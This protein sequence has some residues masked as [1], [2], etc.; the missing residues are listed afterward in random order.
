MRL[1]YPGLQNADMDQEAANGQ[2]IRGAW[3]DAAVIAEMQGVQC[4]SR[5]GKLLQT[6]LK[7]WQEAAMNYNQ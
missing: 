6:A 1:S 2:I 3:H 5:D 4:V 7:H